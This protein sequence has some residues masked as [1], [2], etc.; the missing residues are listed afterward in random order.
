MRASD[1]CKEG[2]STSYDNG[3]CEVNNM[4]QSMSTEDKT[5]NN[6]SLCANCGKEGANNICNKCK[7]V[8]YCNAACKKK[9]RHKHKKDCEEY[10]RLATE[11]HNEELRLAAE[12][13][14]KLHDEKLF[15]QPPQLGDCPICFI[16]LP[17]HDTG[18]RYKSFVEKR[19]AV[20][21]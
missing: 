3:V 1:N 18:N 10:I 11:K 8:R 19:Y 15:K 16:S 20:D 9:H 2:A 4:L 17:T 7:Q 12:Q 13:A 14:T 6:I 21:V 5:N